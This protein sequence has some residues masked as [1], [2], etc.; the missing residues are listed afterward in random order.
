[1]NI[2]FL[3]EKVKS[4]LGAVSDK[5]PVLAARAYGS[6]EGETGEG[7]LVSSA[8][9]LLVFSRR[10]GEDNFRKLSGMFG[11]EISKLDVRQDK[12]NTFLDININGIPYSIKFSSSEQKELE[13][14][15]E[16]LKSFKQESVQPAVPDAGRTP[17]AP[18]V[19]IPASESIKAESS[20]LTPLEM[21]AVSLMYVS[22]CDS[23]I[24]EDE[25]RCILEIFRDN[26]PVLGSALAYY[27]A[28]RYEEFLG[29]IG[30]LSEN[31]KLCILSNMVEIAMKDSS[32]QRTE[33]E[34]LRKFVEASGLK[35]EQYKAIN[36]VLYVKNSTGVLDG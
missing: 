14:L 8:G 15:V 12:F 19:K 28:H 5:I 34:Y 33:Q 24:S 30:S 20:P 22:S 16:S 32:L 31:Q 1:M 36:S 29:N 4:V 10:A 27:K 23:K 6:V 21:L 17:S 3:P 35:E 25:D 18:S 2:A 26:K 11:K 13:N 7:Y 9:R